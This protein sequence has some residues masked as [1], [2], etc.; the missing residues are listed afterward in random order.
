MR[1]FFIFLQARTQDSKQK[2][3]QKTYVSAFCFLNRVFYFIF[4]DFTAEKSP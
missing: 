4:T 1:V 3:K 2:A